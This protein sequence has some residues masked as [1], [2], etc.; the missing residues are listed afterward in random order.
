MAESLLLL[1][2]HL[3]D[4]KSAS[5]NSLGVFHLPLAGE[6]L[7]LVRFEELFVQISDK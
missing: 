7:M 2:Q 4:C 3:L 1:C 6:K 5:F